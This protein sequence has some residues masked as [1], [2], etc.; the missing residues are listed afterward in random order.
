MVLSIITAMA[1]MIDKRIDTRRT[2]GGMGGVEYHW[3]FSAS[4]CY[5]ECGLFLSV[6]AC[7]KVMVIPRKTPRQAGVFSLDNGGGL[8]YALGGRLTIRSALRAAQGMGSMSPLRVT[9]SLKSMAVMRAKEAMKP[10]G[11]LRAVFPVKPKCTLRADPLVESIL[12][13]RAAEAVKPILELR[14]SLV[15]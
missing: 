13:L 9:T 11:E 10:M 3:P 4:A 8:G 6:P 1:V 14:V 12:S 7:R 5:Y 2:L 15:V